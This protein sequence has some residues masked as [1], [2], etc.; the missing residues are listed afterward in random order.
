MR[1]DASRSEAA[2]SRLAPQNFYKDSLMAQIKDVLEIESKR[3]NLE[4]CAVIH[5]FEEGTFYRAYQFSAWLCHRYIKEFKP[6]H[7]KL[8]QDNG[9]LI[10][11]GFPVSSLMSYVNS[12]FK[13]ITVAEKQVDIVL[14]QTLLNGYKDKEDLEKEFRNWRESVPFSESSKQK[15]EEK[16]FQ[17]K[18]LEHLTTIELLNEIACYPLEQRTLLENL[19][20]LL[21][22]KQKVLHIITKT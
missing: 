16:F 1:R 10:F 22:L 2:Q 12:D 6:T 3:E 11:V 8:K 5:L 15:A 20:F 18:D 21:Q 14:P 19:N 7:R 4:Q 13:L 9:T 17:Y